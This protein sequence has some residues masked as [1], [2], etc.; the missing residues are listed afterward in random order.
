[1][2]TRSTLRTLIYSLAL[3]V[4]SVCVRAS[5]ALARV[6]RVEIL[7]RADITGTFGGHTY[8]RVIGRVY[9][10]FDP[11]NSAN[12]QIVDLNLAARNQNGEVSAVSE[13]IML[14]PKDSADSAAL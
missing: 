9:F 1:M 6:V 2:K 11:H 14:R 10:A 8:E 3:G 7:S 13:F 12:K 5:D 4:G